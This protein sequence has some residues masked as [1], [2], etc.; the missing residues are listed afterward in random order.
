MAAAPPGDFEESGDAPA[1]APFNLGPVKT[2]TDGEEAAADE[3]SEDSECSEGEERW[4]VDD[5]YGEM[6]LGMP[7]ANKCNYCNMLACARWESTHGEEDFVC[8]D[9]QER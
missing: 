6:A 9:H 1:L 5:V 2:G 8:V 3:R 4:K 7:D